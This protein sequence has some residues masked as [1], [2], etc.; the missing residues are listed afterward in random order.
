MLFR[1]SLL[2]LIL[3]FAATG[4]GQS[5]QYNFSQLD[6][7]SGLSNNQVNTILRDQQGFLW[8]GTMSGLNRFDGSDLK[9][10][11]SSQGNPTSLV[12]NNVSGL[13]QLPGQEIWVMTRKQPCI[14]N[15]KTEQFNPDY[16]SWLK[17]RQ[18]PIDSLLQIEQ[19]IS[20]SYWFLFNQSG[21][22]QINSAQAVAK[23]FSTATKQS[24]SIQPTSFKETKNGK[25]WLVYKDGL[26][27][28]RSIQTG[29]VEYS[30]YDLD[31]VNQGEFDYRL[32][33][34]SA[35]QPWIYTANTPNGIFYLQEDEQLVRINENTQ[36]LQL[37]NDLITGVLEDREGNIWVS[38]DH[39]GINLLNR[40]KKTVRYLTNDPLNPKS[41]AQ[42]SILTMHQ[43]S[44]G[45]IWL[46]TY[47]QGASYY[48][49]N[50]LQFQHI[51][52]LEAVPGSLPFDDVN[53]FVEDQQGNLWI[54]T[55]GGGLIYY[56][57]QQ[58]SFK[59]YLHD[60]LNAASLSNNVVVSLLV[61]HTN[62]LWVG[63]YF[64]GLSTFDG[65]Q[66]THYRHIEG[67]AG[68][69]SDNRVWEIYQDRQNRIWVGTLNGGLNLLE[70]DQQ[71]FKHFSKESGKV[72][73]LIDNYISSI[74]EDSNGNFWIGTATGITVLSK[75]LKSVR[76][77]QYNADSSASLSNNNVISLLEDKKGRIWIGTREGLNLFQP[78]TNNFQHFTQADGLPDNSIL[79]L[80]EDRQHAIWISTPNGLCKIKA[81][82]QEENKMS[83]TVIKYDES[84]NLQGRE[85]NEN[86]ALL[87]SKGEVILGGPNGFNII[88]PALLN[89]QT[90]I[91]PVLITGLQVYNE[92]VEV[93]TKKNGRVVLPVSITELEELIL[94]HR[95][96][97]FSIEF[98]SLDFSGTP[99]R[100]AYQLEGFNEDWL[101]TDQ[102]QR[103]VTYTNLDPGSY[104]FRV[105]A[106]NNQ[107]EWSEIKSLKISMKPP[108]WLTPLAYMLYFLFVVGLLWLGRRI[109]IERARMR[110]A[111][112]QQKREAERMQAM[113][114]LKTKFFTNVSH[115]FRTPLSLI[116]APLDKIIH[117]T[118]QPDQK[119]QLHLVQ[120]NAKRL[121]NLVNQLLDFR[122]ME[123]EEIRLHASIGDIIG[124]VKEISYSFTDIAEKKSIQFSFESELEHLEM[125]FD[126]DKME[127]ILFNLLSNAYKYTPDKGFVS[128]DIKTNKL[129]GPEQVAI[130]ISDSG[131][132]IAADQ[133]D[134]IFERFFQSELPEN[135][136]NQ[137]TGIGLAITREFVKLHQGTIQ[138]KSEP[139]KGTSFIVRI[140]VRKINTGLTNPVF[141]Q[142]AHADEKKEHRK[143]ILIV[144]DNEDLRFYLKDNLQSSYTIV[145]AVNGRQGWDLVK[146]RNPD[147]VVSD[148]MM[149]ELNGIEL[150][151]LIKGETATAHIPVILLT[152][153]GSEEKQLEG[154]QIG[155][156]DYITKP[157]TFEILASRIQ[158][159]LAQQKLLQKRFQKQ[160]E[161]NPSDITVTLLDEEFIR[162][163]LLIIERQMDN[164][165]FS[166]EEFSRE[167]N[168]SRV[169]LYKKLVSL[170]GK[171][172]LEFIRSIRMKRAA[173]LLKSGK[174]VSEIA[175]E[176]GFN[177]PK[178]FARYFKEEF[179]VI[180]SKYKQSDT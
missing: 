108:F 119:K 54:G 70:E 65:K 159:L 114:R 36:P 62:R 141:N 18:L 129:D 160:L 158:N 55:N 157:F 81:N 115:E 145:E 92:S 174:T 5:R 63:T 133:Q 39:G 104:T 130:T 162:Q 2:F 28:K 52:H 17:E 9:Q 105:K 153:M 140:P 146:S 113:D 124:F 20:G 103:R 137:G 68:S 164:P 91:A 117:Q 111:V 177:N 106:L 131:I 38:T 100:F 123:V 179:G 136:V 53:R 71:Q 96:N 110:F 171:A 78:A 21:L 178:L 40:A 147:L 94:T 161:V 155:I 45:I 44:E 13:Y 82:A 175:Y 42:N 176:V 109:I 8:L 93:G 31:Q 48:N 74:L 19:G 59:R 149:P 30:S 33:A 116:L 77:Y 168:M 4:S 173:Q 10:F 143:T 25:I 88:Q 166:V 15:S 126:K 56:D 107:G 29:Q 122:K 47:K 151:R 3:G 64:G 11:R 121:L 90:L 57:R 170:T 85:F 95:E 87:S 135:M 139:D 138:V 34:D 154:Y 180:P 112:Q 1:T 152:A 97:I 49:A 89:Q 163:A 72:P 26:L 75:D 167:M 127:K 76:H 84:N 79:T 73:A 134:R 58:Q 150:A 6:I 165:D 27:E 169:A 69:L 12:D 46:G 24:R 37:N 98:A 128:V 60:P 66:F 144:E 61:D 41:I 51:H 148:I 125:Y 16:Q 35:G 67:D 172:P 99:N 43:D 142:P 14:Y 7:Y 80:T 22:F 118:I 86:A 156:N 32:F 102:K 50:L 23:K 101:F 120:R 132:G 83:L